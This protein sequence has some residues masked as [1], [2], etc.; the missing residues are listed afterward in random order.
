MTDRV[1]SPLEIR[2]LDYIRAEIPR[3]EEHS[4]GTRDFA[5]EINRDQ[6]LGLDEEKI[7][8]AALCHD[9]ARLMEPG[10][11]VSELKARGIDPDSFGYVIPILLHGI[12]S[13][14][15][16][17]EKIGVTDEETLN[18]I[19]WHVTGQ[20]EMTVLDRLI[21]VSDKV[22]ERTREYP[23]VGELRELVVKDLMK[24][25]P[26]VLAAVITYVVAELQPLDYNSIA[27]YNRAIDEKVN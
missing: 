6:S 4:V 25:Y 3:L 23:G 27:A 11:I 5:L 16:A 24:A 26:R 20:A 21:Y 12:L 22:E 1:K 14:E 19:R 17:K 7:I 8:L 15:L 9:F 10:M 18:A 13:A 2:A